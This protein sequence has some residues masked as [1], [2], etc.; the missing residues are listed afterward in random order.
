[1]TTKQLLTCDSRLKR[2]DRLNDQSD[3]PEAA[4]RQ[5]AAIH[6]TVKQPIRS[7]THRKVRK[8]A[9]KALRRKGGWPSSRYLTHEQFRTLKADSLRIA[10]QYR[11]SIFVSIRP[12]AHLSDGDKKKRVNKRLADLGQALER[13][14]QPFIAL[15]VFEKNAGGSLHGHALVFVLP[16]NLDCVTRWSDVFDRSRAFAQ[17]REGNDNQVETHAALIGQAREDLRKAVMYAIKQHLWAGPG[18]DGA[19][20]ARM[21]WAPAGPPIAGK[22]Y[23]FTKFAVAFLEAEKAKLPDA[24][25]AA[26]AAAAPQTPIQLFLP[27]VAPVIDI[28]SAVEAAR[29][30]RGLT[31]AETGA[32]IG[33]GQ[34]GYSNTFVRRHDPLSPWARLRAIEFIRSRKAA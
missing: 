11:W 15:K 21:F 18:H 29:L 6:S 4:S 7:D 25:V 3:R 31:Q 12:P 2:Q 22:R 32:M 26:P 17:A 16:E 9:R 5:T 27:L 13:R 8:A 30:R 24:A 34:P 10:S 19:G 23:S 28:R 33:Y 14:G 1:M 20:S